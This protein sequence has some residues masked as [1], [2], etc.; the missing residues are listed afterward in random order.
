GGKPQKAQYTMKNVPPGK[1]QLN[2]WHKKL[3]L[4]GGARE[5]VVE[6]GKTTTVDFEITKAKYA[7][8]KD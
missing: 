2:I 4:S 8:K 1:Y 7:K 3:K 6:Q 5:I